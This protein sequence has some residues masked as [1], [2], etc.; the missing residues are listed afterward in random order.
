MSVLPLIFV[1]IVAIE[2]AYILILEMFL[3][4]KPRTMKMFGMS[5]EQAENTLVFAA[6]QGLYNGFLSAGLFW[7]LLHPNSEFGRQL[8]IYFLLCVIVAAVYGCYSFKRSIIVT[9]GLPAF[10]AILLVLFV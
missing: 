7:G 6:N 2:H 10:I 1:A 3:W 5:K 9:Q 4:T 8:Q